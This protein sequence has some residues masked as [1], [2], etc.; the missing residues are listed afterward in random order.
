LP[1]YPLATG[2][3]AEPGG[4]LDEVARAHQATPAQVALAWLLGHSPVMLP[5]P[6]TSQISHFEE[7]LDAAEL[8][9]SQEEIDSLA[10]A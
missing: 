4:A 9:L 3:L 1:W 5:I 2:R 6:G 8:E 7:N 10:G